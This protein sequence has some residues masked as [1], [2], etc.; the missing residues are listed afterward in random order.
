MRNADAAPPSS[1]LGLSCLIDAFLSHLGGAEDAP[2]SIAVTPAVFGQ[3]LARAAAERLLGP[4]G[5]ELEAETFGE[6]RVGNVTWV[7]AGPDLPR[8]RQH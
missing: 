6:I 4:P 1:V 5:A 7:R 3:L 8:A 2:V